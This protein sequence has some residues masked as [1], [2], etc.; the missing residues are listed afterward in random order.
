MHITAEA[1]ST[2]IYM[3]G[4]ND[5]FRLYVTTQ[6]DDVD[7]N[8]AIIEDDFEAPGGAGDFDPAFMKALFEYG[9]KK[10]R[11]GY[12]WK[13]TPPSLQAR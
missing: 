2:M 5:L 1:I 6:L 4:M 8:L 13:K 9:Y 12:P 3:S 11:N 7:Y 10:G